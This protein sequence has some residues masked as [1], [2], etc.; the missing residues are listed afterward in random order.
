MG[1]ISTEITRLKTAKTDIETAIES[2]G[3]NVPDSELI[4]TYA[5]YIRQIPSAIFSELNVDT[6]GGEDK[7]IQSIKQTNGLIEATEGGLVSASNSGLV[8]K[9][10][11]IVSSTITTV[12]DE[13]VLT[14]NKGA[15][16]TWKKLPA[17]VIDNQV[18]FN[19]SNVSLALDWASV[20]ITSTQGI[21]L[22]QSNGFESGVYAIKIT[23]GS[24]MFSGTASIYV[25]AINTDDEIMLHMSGIK[26]QFT[27][28][29]QGRIYAKIAASKTDTNHGELYLATNVPQSNITN[30]SI[31]MKKI[32]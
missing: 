7:F 2:C 16:P 11:T 22:S 27:D 28:G 20:P 3:V 15:T 21:I 18:I 24:L 9:I 1:N 26:Q 14:S 17:S 32:I 30:L 23:S 29:V 25:G 10:G 12:D 6:V 13:W 8:P 5:S 31:T 19:P 4:S